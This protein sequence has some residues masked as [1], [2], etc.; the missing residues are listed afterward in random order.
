MPIKSIEPNFD[1]IAKEIFAKR[2]TERM[3]EMGYRAD[4][5]GDCID[6][7]RRTIVHYMKGEVSPPITTAQKIAIVL[8]CD[9]EDLIK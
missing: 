6:V 9:I 7:P 1:D 3:Q 8:R 4:M 2:L 5:L